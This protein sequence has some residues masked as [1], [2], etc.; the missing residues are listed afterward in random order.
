MSNTVPPWAQG[1]AS[2]QQP[3]TLPSPA[4]DAAAPGAPEDPDLAAARALASFG[5]QV[6]LPPA[7]PAA[8]AARGGAS[9]TMPGNVLAHKEAMW[10]R[11][12]GE[13]AVV[14]TTIVRDPA[15][16]PESDAALSARGVE[17]PPE[18]DLTLR[19]PARR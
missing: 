18:S 19:R 7:H 11:A 8:I 13:P 3:T 9:G 2:G 15:L 14:V 17:P 6:V 12:G 1:S 4:E 10:D 16:E 5:A